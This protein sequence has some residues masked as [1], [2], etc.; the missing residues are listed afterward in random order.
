MNQEH[1]PIILRKAQKAVEDTEAVLARDASVHRSVSQLFEI[2]ASQVEHVISE[3]LQNADDAGA[4]KAKITFEDGYFRFQHNGADFEESQFIA[5]C[6]FSC[7]DKHTVRTTG[8]RGIGFKSTFSLGDSVDLITQSFQVRFERARFRYPIKLSGERPDPEWPITIRIRV[9]AESSRELTQSIESWRKS[10]VSLLFFNNI[11]KGGITVQEAELRVQIKGRRHLILN[12]KSIIWEGTLITRKDIE[13]P[14]AAKQEIS[15]LRGAVLDET[16]RHDTQ[17]DLLVSR[18]E[19]GRIYSVLP[20]SSAKRLALDFAVNASFIL[21]PEREAIKSPSQSATNAFLF[22]EVGR[23]IADNLLRHLGESSEFTD[24]LGMAY[25]LLPLG[26]DLSK[27]DAETAATVIVAETCARELAGKPWLLS[28]DNK[29]IDP[30]K[31]KMVVLPK[32]LFKVWSPELL[33]SIF[34]PGSELL[35]VETPQKVITA[36]AARG[37]VEQPSAKQLLELLSA[38]EIPRPADA[39]SLC[40]LWEWF[41]AAITTGG[42]DLPSA[43]RVWRHAKLIPTE[44][45][46]RLKPYH[47]AARIPATV[48]MALSEAGININD[49]ALYRFDEEFVSPTRLKPGDESAPWWAFV[50]AVELDSEASLDDLLERVAKEISTL[51]AE[52]P[53]RSKLKAIWRLYQQFAL[54]ISR[55]LP[56]L[57]QDGSMVSIK[58]RPLLLDDRITPSTREWI[59]DDYHAEHALGESWYPE[60]QEERLEFTAWLTTSVQCHSFPPLMVTSS[61]HLRAG[62]VSRYALSEFG[63]SVPTPSRNYDYLFKNYY[64]EKPVTTFWEKKCLNDAG[65]R[66]RLLTEIM[67]HVPSFSKSGLYVRLFIIFNASEVE[68]ALV[69]LI[70]STATKFFSESTCLLDKV[71]GW[72]KPAELLVHN[73]DTASL[74]NAGETQL[75]EDCERVI[76][77]ELLKALGCRTELPDISALESLLSST[78]RDSEPSCHRVLCLL[79]AINQKLRLTSSPLPVALLELLLRSQSIPSAQG[80]LERVENLVQDAEGREDIQEVH[81]SLKGSLVIQALNIAQTAGREADIEWISSLELDKALSPAE[82][83]RLRRLLS[84]TS[85]VTEALFEQKRRWLGLDGALHGLDS[86]RYVHKDSNAFKASFIQ[87]DRI[88]SV[89]ADLNV[90]REPTGAMSGLQPALADSVQSTIERSPL[91]KIAQAAWIEVIAQIIWTE[92]ELTTEQVVAEGLEAAALRLRGTTLMLD[93]QLSRHVTLDGNALATMPV[94]AVWQEHELLLRATDEDEICQ[95]A[96]PI[97][98]ELCRSI[99][100]LKSGTML[101]SWIDREPSKIRKLACRLLECAELREWPAAELKAETSMK[102]SADEAASANSAV[103]GDVDSGSD[104]ASPAANRTDTKDAEPVDGYI[105]RSGRPDRSDQLIENSEDGDQQPRPPAEGHNRRSDPHQGPIPRPPP[106]HHGESEDIQWSAED[107]RRDE[108]EDNDSRTDAGGP[109]SPGKASRQNGF[110][111]R[112]YVVSGVNQEKRRKR[113][114]AAKAAGDSAEKHVIDWE[115]KQGR[116]ATRQPPNNPGFDIISVTR[117]GTD[118]RFIEVKSISGEWG[119]QGVYLSAS[120]FEFAQ[121]QG[122]QFWLYVVENA[123]TNHPVVHQIQN[124]VA[125]IA[126]FG[127]DSGW[128]KLPLIGQTIPQGGIPQAGET[129]IFDDETASVVRVDKV[130]AF[131]ALTLRFADGSTLRKMSTLVERIPKIRG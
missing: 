131:H 83:K 79:M 56:V 5:L 38:D 98:K 60:N 49:F 118:R 10:P 55:E 121:K 11:S 3:L 51:P 14:V 73:S 61:Q 70:R 35:H 108:D 65:A 1:A 31:T 124:P 96:E 44:L 123:A 127:F 48:T 42:A 4:T 46:D 128:I 32:R 86:F 107:Q 43:I 97:A 12:H 122:D 103:D 7:S 36:L 125:H 23:L 68:Q 34:A 74:I 58:A 82:T 17:I 45:S 109:L 84:Q 92:A 119:G 78:L 75:H 47:V 25:E 95:L 13:L 129:V 24:E 80:R 54:K 53:Q 6:S 2:V 111:G 40:Y 33:K 66:Y 105:E 37:Q 59:P 115:A 116:I 85:S 76:P 89:I 101:P 41:S 130:G 19:A 29:R 110:R 91:A 67:K 104:N 8:F 117:E 102:N 87:D 69:P 99:A 81:A 93:S 64:F 71:G 62:S 57:R 113:R 22:T 120:Q 52:H 126:E 16:K 88:R 18:E 100:E 72:R 94:I 15:K 50:Q 112:S 39:R 20:T 28:A 26:C 63:V 77:I 21:R 90:I 106:R 114:I 9:R 27:A 30:E